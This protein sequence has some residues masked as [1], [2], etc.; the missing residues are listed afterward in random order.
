[1]PAS[2]HR[3][4]RVGLS[5]PFLAPG[6]PTAYAQVTLFLPVFPDHALPI[7]VFAHSSFCLDKTC[8]CYPQEFSCLFLKTWLPQTFYLGAFRI[9]LISHSYLISLLCSQYL[10]GGILLIS[11]PAIC[12]FLKN[13]IYDHAGFLHFTLSSTKGLTLSYSYLSSQGLLAQFLTH[14]R[15]LLVQ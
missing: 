15:Y 3:L 11:L 13:C 6:T 7:Q 12:I 4:D 8:P 10:P 2:L 9:F 1:M 5:R 14:N